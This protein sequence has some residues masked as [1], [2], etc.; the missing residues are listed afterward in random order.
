M[1]EKGVLATLFDLSFTVFIT[2]RIIKLLFIL[3]IVLVAFVTL[4]LVL[5]ASTVHPV[6][7]LLLLALSP[8]VFLLGVLLVRLW[9]EMTIVVFNI[10]G[11]TRRLVDQTQ[12]R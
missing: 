7:G 12:P 1:E 11:N 10:A 8:V 5:A 2:T 6:F 4:A 9:C 3:G